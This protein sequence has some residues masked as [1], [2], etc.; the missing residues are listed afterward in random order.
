MSSTH[1]ERPA[2]V[3]CRLQVGEHPVSASSSKARYILSEDPRRSELGD[4]SG[5]LKEES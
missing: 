5:E 2:G 1:H 4:D 3:A